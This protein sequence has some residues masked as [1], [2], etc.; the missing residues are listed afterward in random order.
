M[1]SARR[2]D[3]AQRSHVADSAPLFLNLRLISAEIWPKLEKLLN[4][5]YPHIRQRASTA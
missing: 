4:E 3:I 1:T 5:R 2:R